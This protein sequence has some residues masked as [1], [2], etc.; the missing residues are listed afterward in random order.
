MGVFDLIILMKIK[1]MCE[2]FLVNPNVNLKSC[3]AE[4]FVSVIFVV[5]LRDGGIK[6]GRVII[7]TCESE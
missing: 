4:V 2:E 7:E 1:R 5:S 6:K 3:L